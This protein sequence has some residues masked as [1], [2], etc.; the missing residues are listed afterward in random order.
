MDP[1]FV[2]QREELQQKVNL[3]QRF[4]AGHGDAAAVVKGLVA[5]IIFQD[6]LRLHE[7]SRIHLPRVRVVTVRTT[8]RTSLHKHYISHAGAVNCSKGL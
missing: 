7:R 8:H 6:F 2:C 4:T 5:L 1:T 3:H